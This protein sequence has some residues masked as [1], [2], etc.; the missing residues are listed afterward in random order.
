MLKDE[1]DLLEVLKFELGF[2]QDGG[3]GRSPKTP[4]RP[5]YIFEDSPTCANY[6]CKENPVPCSDCV[7]MQ[8]VPQELRS[9]KIPCRHIPFNAHGETLDSLYR[10]KDQ[11]E[12]E[13]VVESWLKSTI[14]HLEEQRA[15][16]QQSV[17]KKSP[18]S[19]DIVKGMPLY[20]KQH[21]KWANPACPTAFHWTGGGKFFRFRP[22]PVFGNTKAADPPGGIHGVRHYWLCERCSQ[23]LT[24]VYCEESGVVLKA[25]WPELVIAESQ[26]AV[27]A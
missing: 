9:S 13:K 20:Q 8:L 21:P 11:I 6:D 14:A 2:L 4:W 10:Y 18:R 22:D 5:R 16:I 19:S 1:R 27:S 23:A 7:L 12:I 3:Y 24:L 17:H 25:L 15:S 26:K